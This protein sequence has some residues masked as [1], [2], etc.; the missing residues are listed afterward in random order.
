RQEWENDAGAHC[1]RTACDERAHS[2]PKP[3]LAPVSVSGL[4]PHGQEPRQA[5]DSG[6]DKDEERRPQRAKEH[7]VAAEL[8][9]AASRDQNYIETTT[10]QKSKDSCQGPGCANGEPPKPRQQS[11]TSNQGGSAENNAKQ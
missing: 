4:P 6:H 11:R 1:Q 7:K 2:P 5:S 8:L 9:P 10:H 3:S